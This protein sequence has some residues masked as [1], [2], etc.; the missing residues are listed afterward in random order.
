MKTKSEAQ[1]AARAL[2]V[3]MRDPSTWK[4]RVWENA[5]WHCM[6]YRGTLQICTTN[7]GPPY[8]CLLGYDISEAPPMGGA[9]IWLDHYSG[10]DPNEAVKQQL[11]IA[12]QVHR[13]IERVLEL[14]DPK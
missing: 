7:G 2:K 4:V 3:R 8:S 5:G 11:K 12:R 14:A 10:S 6:L 9:A 13:R 1:K